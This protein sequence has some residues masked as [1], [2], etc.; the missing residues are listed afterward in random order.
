MSYVYWLKNEK[1]GI[2]EALAES[3]K[4]KHQFSNKE[5]KMR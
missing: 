1:C 3:G 2:Q 4:G 5:G